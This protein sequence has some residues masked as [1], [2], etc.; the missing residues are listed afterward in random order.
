MKELSK[1]LFFSLVS[2][3]PVTSEEHSDKST[4]GRKGS[5]CFRLKPLE[6]DGFG[7]VHH[8]LERSHCLVLR[9]KQLTLTLCGRFLP[10]HPGEQSKF[11]GSMATW[12]KKADAFAKHYLVLFKPGVGCPGWQDPLN[13]SSFCKWASVVNKRNSLL[14]QWILATMQHFERG[15]SVPN[16]QRVLMNAYRTRGADS[17]SEEEST[18][19]EDTEVTV[20]RRTTRSQSARLNL[21]ATFEGFVPAN[22]PNAWRDRDLE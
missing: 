21:A 20:P 12:Q 6:I 5:K 10:K 8:K 3:V 19:E 9:S 13:W 14:D 1:H 11:G 7:T 15:F 16:K 17:W 22:N 2:I 4:R 18:I